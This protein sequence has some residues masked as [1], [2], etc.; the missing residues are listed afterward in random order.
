MLSL[1][2]YGQLPQK[3]ITYSAEDYGQIKVLDTQ[4]VA[5]G[6]TLFTIKNGEEFMLLDYQHDYY[7]IDYH[8]QQGYVYYPYLKKIDDIENYNKICIQYHLN[9]DR[10]IKLKELEKLYGSDNANKILNNNIWIGMT[11]DMCLRSIGLPT[12][13]NKTTNADGNSDQWVYENKYLYF[14]NGVL[15]TWQEQQK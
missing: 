10:A 8:N 14:D 4:S 7:L 3:Q 12:I 1:I 6:K 2:G 15:T 5:F 11:E 9:L 13:K